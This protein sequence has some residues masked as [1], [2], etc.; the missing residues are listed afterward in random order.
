MAFTFTSAGQSVLVSAKYGYLHNGHDKHIPI[1][2]TV[3][4]SSDT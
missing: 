2:A 4:M 3:I 1:C